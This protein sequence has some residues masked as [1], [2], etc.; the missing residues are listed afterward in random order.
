M[1]RRFSL[2]HDR[3]NFRFVTAAA[4]PKPKNGEPHNAADEMV[5]INAG[6]T[7]VRTK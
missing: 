3:A 1:F 4:Q 7:G 5:I 2:V 6:I